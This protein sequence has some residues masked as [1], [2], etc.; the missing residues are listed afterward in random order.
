MPG[1]TWLQAIH[2]D[3]RE[4]IRTCRQRA[5]AAGE[6]YGAEFRLKNTAGVYCWHVGRVTPV[7][8]PDGAIVAWL[9]TAADIDDLRRADLV[10]RDGSERLQA[11]LAGS[12]TGTFRWDLRTNALTWDE[13]LDRLFGLAPGQT[14]RSLDAFV[15]LVHPDDRVAVLERCRACAQ[16]GAD[17]DMEFR[18]VWRDG[19]VHWIDDKGRTFRDADGAPAYMTGAC[20]DM[21]ERKA[22]EDALRRS[23]ERLRFT[24]DAGG[25]GAWELDLAT[26]RMTCTARCKQNVGAPADRPLTYEQLI[27]RI[28]PDDRAAVAAAVQDAIT[29]AEPY[30]A[31]YRV[32]TDEGAVRWVAARGR[33]VYDPATG[34]PVLMS[35]VTTDVTRVR[36]ADAALRASEQRFAQLADT[37]P[38]IVWATDADGGIQYFNRRWVEYTGLPLERSMGANWADALH[39]GDRDAAVE[40][41]IAAVR[42][43]TPFENEHR[44]R[45]ADGQYRW[46]LARGL[47][48]RGDA[49]ATGAI[50]HWFGTCTDIHDSK[51]TRDA[52][53]QAREEAE[54]A[55][56]AKDE[57]LAALSHELRTPLAPVLLM[58]Q[59]L[60]SDHALPEPVRH[61]LST[62]RRNVEI[63][64]RLIDDLLDLTRIARGKVNLQPALTDFHAIVRH[65]VDTCRD[66]LFLQKRL[67]LHLD[68]RADPAGVW[69]DPARLGQVVWNLVKNATKFTPEG[70]A[71]TVRTSN[72]APTRVDLVV[73]DTGIG[74][75]PQ[76]LP[77]IF[78]AFEQ[79]GADVTRRFGGLG[80]GLAISRTLVEMHGGRI[81]AASPG[82]GRGATF[83]VH[84]PAR[85]LP[86]PQRDPAVVIPATAIHASSAAR[87]GKSILV[88]EDHEQSGKVLHRLL[89]R[90]GY[91]VEWVE[92]ANAALRAAR[93]R[94]FDLV[95][96]D[97]GLPDATGHDVMRQLREQFNARGIALSGYGMEDDLAR[98]AESG[99]LRHLVKP[100]SLDVLQATLR[101]LIG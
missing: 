85:P 10:H 100:V 46:H 59:M 95:I 99:F 87:P 98:S 54:R 37:M 6:P 39:P 48:I 31:E 29:S 72:P 64:V 69:A 19:S 11:A 42:A 61:D 89:T 92:T 33:A 18:V 1:L 22:R 41:W 9:G 101:D 49:T 27:G 79:G 58:T 52:L 30:D 97:L 20:V 3:D 70:G 8:A 62:I 26:G 24:L 91:Q 68:L 5:I 44:F 88:V 45:R 43:G 66:D 13:N 96:S 35:G 53:Q 17:F 82:K 36:A 60:E 4:S 25:L 90:L 77:T 80:L 76:M 84:L 56:R 7:Q 12:G 40:R 93:Q 83:T 51:L 15:A 73:A 34:R 67:T 32:V 74:I 38:Q 75:D 81:V 78:D 65:A 23:E 55:N 16:R 86:A 28:H 63:E 57:F 47:P 50:T 14:P 21:T 94:P 71:I 2:P